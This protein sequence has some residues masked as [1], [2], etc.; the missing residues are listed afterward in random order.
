MLL[1]G[2]VSNVIN[3]S[4]AAA[5]SASVKIRFL[6]EGNSHYYWM[7]DDFAVIEGPAKRYGIKN[8]LFRV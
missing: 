5:N 6:S 1:R 3:I 4:T 8:S 7:I 2:T